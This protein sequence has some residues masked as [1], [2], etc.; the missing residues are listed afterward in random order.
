MRNDKFNNSVSQTLSPVGRVGDGLSCVA[1]I[2]FFDGVHRGHCYLIERV[3]SM[4]RADGLKSMV[5]TFDRH[6]REVLQSDYRPQMLTTLAEKVRLLRDTGVDRVEVLHFTRSLAALSARDFMREVLRDRLGVRKLVIGYDHRFGH[7]RAEGFDDYVRYGQELGIEVVRNTE[8]RLN[9]KP[10]DTSL[11]IDGNSCQG[12]REAE[13]SEGN[14]VPSAITADLHL[15]SSTVRRLL[16]EGNVGIAA[17]LL[18]RH[19]ML[20]GHVAHGQAEGRRMGFPTANLDT[21]G[22]PLLVPARGV[23]A[24]AVRVCADDAQLDTLADPRP[25]TMSLDS[26]TTSLAPGWLPAMLNIG[27]RPTF[28]GTA[29]TIEA[30]ILNFAGDI[31]GRPMAVAFF[32]RIRDERRFDS[33]EALEDQL[34]EDRA[35][36]AR[37]FG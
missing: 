9:F 12:G 15:S 19:H 31:Y 34:H 32:D 1:T 4:A 5:I 28:G 27:H 10:I 6:P 3:K 29:T 36:V 17:L 20:F 7:N 18:D 23:Y 24:V 37:Y 8:M 22:Y 21:T 11:D 33:V 25:V 26:F 2:G 13:S 30:H 35:A 14:K 16:A